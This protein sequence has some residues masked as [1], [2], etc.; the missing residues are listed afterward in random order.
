MPLVLE[1][2]EPALNCLIKLC[3]HWTDHVDAL[4]AHFFFLQPQLLS[5][6]IGVYIKKNNSRVFVVKNS[7]QVMFSI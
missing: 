1:N 2:A 5:L 7:L 6:K 3:R 4:E